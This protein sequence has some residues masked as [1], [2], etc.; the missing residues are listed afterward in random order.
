MHPEDASDTRQQLFFSSFLPYHLFFF[1]AAR[2]FSSYVLSPPCTCVYVC[3]FYPTCFSGSARSPSLDSQRF[4]R[5][6]VA[7]RVAFFSSFF[8]LSLVLLLFYDFDPILR[9]CVPAAF[10]TTTSKS[11]HCLKTAFSLLHTVSLSNHHL[12]AVC[13]FHFFSGPSSLSQSMKFR[14][15]VRLL[16]TQGLFNCSFCSS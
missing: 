5:P 1:I 6:H 7:L 15:C 2:L 10:R 12:S 16:A 4:T 9:D 14:V 8:F 3:V 13:P 11:H